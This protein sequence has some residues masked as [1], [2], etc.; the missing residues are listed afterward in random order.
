MRGVNTCQRGCFIVNWLSEKLLLCFEK[1]LDYID[2][3]NQEVMV[4]LLHIVLP[5]WVYFPIDSANGELTHRKIT[6]DLQEN[7]VEQMQWNNTTQS[8]HQ[9]QYIFQ[10]SLIKPLPSGELTSKMPIYSWFINEQFQCSIFFVCLAGN[11]TEIQRSFLGE[12]Q[13]FHLVV[14]LQGDRLGW[15]SFFLASA[16]RNGYQLPASFN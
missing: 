1:M 3:F 13:L 7:T 8:V 2:H 12:T 14:R 9:L 6:Q 4:L 16:S 15:S 5:I 11:L 10:Q